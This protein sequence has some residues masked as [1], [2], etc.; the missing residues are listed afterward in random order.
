MKLDSVVHNLKQIVCLFMGMG[1][2]LSYGQVMSIPDSLVKK[3][4]PYLWKQ[5]YKLGDRNPKAE[6][7]AQAILKKGKLE[8]DTDV[9]LS[10]YNLLADMF[11]ADYKMSTSYID[12]AIVASTGMV[13]QK[14]PAK[15]YAKKA[16]IERFHGNFK[17]SL[18]NYLKQIESAGKSGVSIN[19]ANYNIALLKRQFGYYD[20]AKTILKTCL[21]FDLEYLKKRPTDSSGYF[22]TI[23]ELVK[24]Y[25]LDNE[26]DSAAALN[27]RNKLSA[28]NNDVGFLFI[29]N[30]GILDY[31]NKDYKNAIKKITSSIPELIHK[32]NNGY[33]ELSVLMDAYLYLGKSYSALSE[34]E[35]KLKYYKKLDSLIEVS[36][37]I[38]P[39]A[40]SVYLELID[41]YKNLDDKNKQLYYIDKFIYVDSVVD[42]NYKY[43]SR[44]FTADYD[45]PKL[46]SEK[47][48]L[49][50]SMK[51][52]QS[53]NSIR[54]VAIVVLLV[55]SVV[56]L[57]YFY[58]KQ[59]QYKDRFNAL[60][61]ETESLSKNDVVS[62]P[63]D[64][65]L[66]G[67]PSE[68]VKNIL[69]M[70]AVFEANK[71]YLKSNI[72]AQRLAKT[73]GTNSKYLSN[74][75]NAS[76]KKSLSQYINDLRIEFSVQKLK[77]DHIYRK[78]TIQA[79]A[80]EIGFNTAEAFS[81]AFQKKTGILPSYFIKEL[82]KVNE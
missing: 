25:R 26:F 12:S 75:V 46:L 59:K 52:E 28:I 65:E 20:D 72:T 74:V 5:F 55:L 56:G 3:D 69:G 53:T 1:Y 30:E 51:V 14:Y 35:S 29:Q 58:W 57:G 71:G 24:T 67:V 64:G 39:D 15:L 36:N 22:C 40:K 44:R 7:Y 21:E 78:Y 47:E 11:E 37:Y 45:I 54:I 41:Y 81:K 19:Y 63:K 80:N 18:D 23:S 6:L 73:L 42:V 43:L 77:T 34:P 66:S 49:I 62:E 82:I 16:Y 33:Y 2:A 61:N 79:I 38:I 13:H 70:L 8:G 60:V 31:H 17:A 10:G 48:H 9:L 4:Y 27:S 68:T 76:K 50:A 32:D